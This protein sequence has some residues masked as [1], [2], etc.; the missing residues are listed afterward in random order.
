MHARA[1]VTVVGLCVCVCLS[2]LSMFQHET[3]L[4]IYCVELDKN[5]AFNTYGVICL[6][7]SFS[8]HIGDRTRS[9]KTIAKKYSICRLAIVA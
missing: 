9:H 5:T 1:R 6:P 2:G 7:Q 4:S 8:V 3:R